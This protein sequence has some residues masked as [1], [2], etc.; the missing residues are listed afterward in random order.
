MVENS[1]IL[2][3]STEKSKNV[4]EEFNKQASDITRKILNK[5]S[6]R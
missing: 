6:S 3:V 2:Q 5:Y 1:K 4:I